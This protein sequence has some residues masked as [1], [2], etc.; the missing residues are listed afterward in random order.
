[1]HGWGLRLRRAAAC[2]RRLGKTCQDGPTMQT[3]A[4]ATPASAI[5]VP[6]IDSDESVAVT[7]LASVAPLDG[8]PDGERINVFAL[9]TSDGKG[10]RDRNADAALAQLRSRVMGKPLGY[11]AAALALGYVLARV[12]R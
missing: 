1:V 6:D 7:P 3:I 5:P 12:L 2:R 9:S 10:A 11:A 8:P 4:P